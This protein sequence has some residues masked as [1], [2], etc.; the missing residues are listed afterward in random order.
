MPS[1]TTEVPVPNTFFSSIKKLTAIELP[2]PSIVIL[3]CEI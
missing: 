3:I 1:G 2:V